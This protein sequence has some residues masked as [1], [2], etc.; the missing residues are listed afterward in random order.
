ML[1]DTKREINMFNSVCLF[2]CRYVCMYLGMDDSMYIQMHVCIW[3]YVIRPILNRP[4]NKIIIQDR[5][6]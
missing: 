2:V 5:Y 1:K 3:L 6:P 4:I